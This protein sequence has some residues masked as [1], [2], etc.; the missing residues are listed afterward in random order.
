MRV[1]EKRTALRYIPPNPRGCKGC[2]R[3][4][5]KTHPWKSLKQFTRRKNRDR[6]K[7]SRC[8]LCSCWATAGLLLGPSCAFVWFLLA[9]AGPCCVL[10]GPMLSTCW[11]SAGT[12]LGP[13][14]APLGLLLALAG[15][16]LG[17]CWAATGPLLGPCWAPIGS[18]LWPCCAPAGPL[19]GP[20]QNARS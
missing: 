20:R 9:P 17:P 11:T 5:Q 12:L 1:E 18:L 15:L 7:H 2:L 3:P 6:Q 4:K 13:C 10:A 16:S 14:C 19:L 8:L